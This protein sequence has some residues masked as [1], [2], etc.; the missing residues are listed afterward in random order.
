MAKSPMITV[1]TGGSLKNTMTFLKRIRS[2]RF[3]EKVERYARLGVEKLAEATPK[4]TG[5]TASSW[6]Y[7]ISVDNE[8]TTITWVNDN[9]VDDWCNVA[10]ILQYGHATRNGGYVQGID[11]INPAIEGLF[12]QYAKELWREVVGR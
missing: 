10:L 11:Y 12:N 1:T 4:D 3:I 6:R 8:R 5:K 7:V 9:V 2:K